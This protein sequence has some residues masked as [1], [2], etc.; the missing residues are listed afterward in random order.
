MKLC[1]VIATK[2]EKVLKRWM[3]VVQGTI[4][5]ES[6]RTTELLDHLPKFLD[7]LVVALRDATATTP[8]SPSALKDPSTAV[9][10]GAQRFR[11]GFSLDE[12]V[13]E[14]GALRG[15]IV[16]T[17]RDEGVELTIDE[18]NVLSDEITSG[19][20]H[21]V[22]EYAHQRD[23]ELARHANEHF[24]FIA[25]ELR[26]PLASARTALEL[27]KAKKLVPT[28]GRAI[29]ALERGLTQTAELIEQSLSTA[30]L[31]SGIELDREETTLK[32]LFEKAEIG[33]LSDAEVKNI[34]IRLLA[35]STEVVH[36]D[37]RLVSSALGNL[38]GNAVKYSQ[39]NSTVEVR[40]R[41]SGGRVIIEVEDACGGLAPGQVEAAFAP[42]VR[43]DQRQSGFGLGLAIA[44]Q[45]A[46]AHGGSIRVQNIPGKGCVFVLNL[47]QS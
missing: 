34:T 10:H 12:V 5:P 4:A 43:F 31:A 47:P 29:E 23:A 45:A 24:A 26:N 9:G 46:D 33:A 1:D 17:A 18:L 21:A 28:E 15:A 30:R 11:L 6:I 36:V 7:A 39:P 37:E 16:A 40:G 3:A 42:F 2:Q 25:H 32:T 27:L 22:S 44:K 8:S 14:Y 13:R 19:I 20:A 35:E 38:L 41:T